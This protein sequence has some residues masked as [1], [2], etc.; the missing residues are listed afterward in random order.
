V[1]VKYLFLVGNSYFFVGILERR[2][3]GPQDISPL[4]GLFPEATPSCGTKRSMG[5]PLIDRQRVLALKP[6]SLLT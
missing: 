1:R 4:A 6:L 2:L 5:P 3:R